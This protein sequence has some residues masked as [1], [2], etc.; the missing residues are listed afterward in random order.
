MSDDDTIKRGSVQTSLEVV[1]LSSFIPMNRVH[2]IRE[3]K[4]NSSIQNS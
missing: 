3:E 4:D 2:S 1:A